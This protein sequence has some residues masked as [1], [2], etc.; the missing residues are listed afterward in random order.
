MLILDKKNKDYYDGV[1]GTTGIDKSI[2]YERNTIELEN[3][4]IP[5]PFS[6]D[7]SWKKY[8]DNIVINLS[9]FKLKK[10]YEMKYFD[11]SYFIIGFCGK[12]YVGCKSYY[13]NGNVINFDIS[14][15]MNHMK[16]CII[17]RTYHDGFENT[18]NNIQKLDTINIFREYNTPIFLWDYC[19]LKRYSNRFSIYHEKNVKFF[20]NPIL[21][22]YEFYK[23]FDTYQ[24]FQEIQMFIS[25][26]L[27]NKENNVVII[28]DK[29]KIIQHG[30][31]KWS[32]RK[33]SKNGKQDE[34]KK[35]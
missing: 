19:Y 34:R 18:I 6:R 5:Y 12:L 27:G 32:F 35:Q 9:Y 24:T 2:I 30:F 31:D 25:G 26:V 21:K 16:D 7:I 15:D 33:E 8:R 3:K 4:N 10:D 23:V 22:E 11:I 29:D 28:S 13:M 17:D 1:A 20:I 14:Y